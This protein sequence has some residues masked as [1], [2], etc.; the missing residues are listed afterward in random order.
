MTYLKNALVWRWLSIL[1][2]V[3]AQ[4]GRGDRYEPT[5][6]VLDGLLQLI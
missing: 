5:S 1:A 4:L 3:F 2:T 6:R